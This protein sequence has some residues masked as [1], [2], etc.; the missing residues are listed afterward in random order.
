M[1]YLWTYNKSKCF[2]F[3]WYNLQCFINE[4]Y[5]KKYRSNQI[6]KWWL[7]T[8]K[9][10]TFQN[11]SKRTRTFLKKW[12]IWFQTERSEVFEGSLFRAVAPLCDQNWIPDIF[13]VFWDTVALKQ[14]KHI[15]SWWRFHILQVCL[16][17][18]H[19]WPHIPK[20]ELFGGPQIRLSILAVKSDQNFVHPKMIFSGFVAK[21]RD[22]IFYT[23]IALKN[24]L[25]F[26]LA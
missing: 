26:I 19:F 15:F 3:R 8:E 23:K 2:D 4:N 22:K 10:V 11:L 1:T 12:C 7:K 18:G 17:S 14:W 5:W 25:L 21:K 20:F 6:E 13:M 16:F 9:L 24:G